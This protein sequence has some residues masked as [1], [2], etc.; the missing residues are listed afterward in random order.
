M[1]VRLRKLLFAL[2]AL[3]PLGAW[4]QPGL[5]PGVRG[6][7]MAATRS[8]VTYLDL[9]RGLVES[10]Q[11]GDRDSVLRLLADGFEVRSA[12]DADADAVPA[13]EWLQD[14]ARRTTQAGNMRELSVRE[15]DDVA[16][17]S[18]LLDRSR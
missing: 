4:A 3:S 2:I 8:V 11:K 5:P 9:E 14:Q 15:F 16:V 12:T 18:F 17:V 13:A 1:R 6:P 7:G 10:L